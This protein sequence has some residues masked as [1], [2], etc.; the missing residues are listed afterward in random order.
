M[1]R[2][3]G[4]KGRRRGL[5][6][7]DCGCGPSWAERVSEPSLQGSLGGEPGFLLV[8]AGPQL[9]SLDSEPGRRPAAV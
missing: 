1:S 9:A 2:D 5:S 6:E 3:S 7:G 8:E 4:Q